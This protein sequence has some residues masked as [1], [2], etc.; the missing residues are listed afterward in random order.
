MSALQKD[1]RSG[2]FCPIK[3]EIEKR[4]LMKFLLWV[5][6]KERN[7]AHC[8]NDEKTLNEVSGKRPFHANHHMTRTPLS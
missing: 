8:E 3:Y 1:E 6:G 4:A 7:T 5:S 2:K